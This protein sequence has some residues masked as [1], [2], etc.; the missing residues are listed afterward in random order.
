MKKEAQLYRE[1]N[2]IVSNAQNEMRNKIN[3]A[4]KDLYNS[5]LQISEQKKSSYL[6]IIDTIL[7]NTGI[8]CYDILEKDKNILIIMYRH[9]VAYILKNKE[10]LTYNKIGEILNRDHST[11]IHSI[12]KT[13]ECLEFPI[14]NEKHY[15]ILNKCLNNYLNLA[16]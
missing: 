9:S 14:Q 4:S 5:L 6:K 7:K 2:L 8:D 13:E 11:I 3:Q 12:K 10:K 15:N 1:Y 16:K